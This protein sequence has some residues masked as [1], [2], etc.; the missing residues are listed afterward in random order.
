[1]DKD[2]VIVLDEDED[3][4]LVNDIPS[5]FQYET[6][7]GETA[8]TP[9]QETQVLQTKRRVVLEDIVIA[10]LPKNYGLITYDGSVITVS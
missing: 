8:V 1:M 10:P 9:S 4:V 2:I 3:I 5:A 7:T 6:Y